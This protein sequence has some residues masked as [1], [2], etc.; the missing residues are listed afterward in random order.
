[1]ESVEDLMV[2]K[3]TQSQALVHE[4]LVQGFI[5]GCERASLA[6]YFL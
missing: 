4:A 1:M 6:K 5:Y 2:G 3:E